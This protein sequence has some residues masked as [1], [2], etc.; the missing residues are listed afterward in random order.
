MFPHTNELSSTWVSTLAPILLH[1]SY[2]KQ[3]RQTVT[4]WHY[5]CKI[6]IFLTIMNTTEWSYSHLYGSLET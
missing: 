1:L 3:G 4:N 5:L 6:H 2:W